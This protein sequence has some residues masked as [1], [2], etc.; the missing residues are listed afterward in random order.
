M[1]RLQKQLQ[2]LTP[3]PTASDTFVD[4]EALLTADGVRLTYDLLVFTFS[5]T[6]RSLSG[7]FRAIPGIFAVVVE[8]IRYI[9]L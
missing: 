4:F 8:Y 9:P 3:S 1:Q 7:S 2:H 5:L 6:F